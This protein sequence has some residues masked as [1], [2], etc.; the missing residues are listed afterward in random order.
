MIE[1]IPYSKE[2]NIDDIL[3]ESHNYIEKEISLRDLAI[4]AIKTELLAIID[5]EWVSWLK[6]LRFNYRDRVCY[7]PYYTYQL[8]VSL[9]YNQYYSGNHHPVFSLKVR[10]ELP[11]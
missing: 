7:L 8:E 1:G 9:T 3:R 5:E 6:D 4:L 10:P 11:P 2:F